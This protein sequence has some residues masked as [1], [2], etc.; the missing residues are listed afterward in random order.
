MY[1][2]KEKNRH[3]RELVDPS[4][5]QADFT[6]LKA[7]DP[8]NATVMAAVGCPSKY[9]DQILFA[10]LEVK[11]REEIVAN[12][13]TLSKANEKATAPKAPK[14]PKADTAPKAPKVKTPKVETPKPNEPKEAEKKSQPKKSPST[15]PSAGTKSST[16]K[17]K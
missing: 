10:L 9:A 1:S 4:H 11:T 2:F 7:S 12:R 8:T 3:Y 5:A 17:Y 6:L 13:R 14:A 15:Q 16:K